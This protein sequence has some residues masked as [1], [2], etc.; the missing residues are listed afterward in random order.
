MG[1]TM[2][3]IDEVINADERNIK[4]LH[5]QRETTKRNTS[6]LQNQRERLMKTK[7]YILS[8]GAKEQKVTEQ[9]EKSA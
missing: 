6:S 9:R 1:S 8:C 5:E 2:K 4:S 3:V 7:A